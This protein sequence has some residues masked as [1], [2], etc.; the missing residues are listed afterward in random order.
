MT[1]HGES[2]TRKF[3]NLYEGEEVRAEHNGTH[4]AFQMRCRR[5][6][7]HLPWYEFAPGGQW[8]SIGS[9]PTLDRGLFAA[10]QLRT[11]TR[12]YDD[13][14]GLFRFYDEEVYA[15]LRADPSAPITPVP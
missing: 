11:G 5:I 8:T 14:H 4:W 13:S 3:A 7:D 6:A 15:E 1:R 2:L 9:W 12:F 10:A